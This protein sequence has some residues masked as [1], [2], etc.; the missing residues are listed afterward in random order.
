MSD[1]NVSIDSSL[2][3][4][5]LEKIQQKQNDW[6]DELRDIGIVFLRSID[7]NFTM[8]GRP[9][10]WIP[11]HAARLRNGMTLIDSGRLRRSVSVLGDNDNVFD[12]GNIT[13]RMSTDIPYA[14]YLHESRP[15]F[16]VQDE[17]IDHAGQIIANSIENL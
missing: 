16:I 14:K 9:I 6:K 11:S 4:R 7:R 13:L 10:R 17:D 12:L 15:F 8:Q 2:I 3:R 1:F 5:K